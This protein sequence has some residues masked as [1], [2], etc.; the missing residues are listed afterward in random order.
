MKC[1]IWSGPIL[2]ALLACSQGRAGEPACAFPADSFLQRL[3][4]VGGW[5]PYG[6]GLLHWWD[7]CCFPRCGGPDDYC[8][9]PLPPMC[10]PCYLSFY[11]WGP[12]EVCPPRCTGP[13][14][15]PAH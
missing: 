1:H 6:G 14:G 10:W 12:P 4:A 13:D 7:S 3:H 11:I 15:K 2:I 8:R 5:N 9:K